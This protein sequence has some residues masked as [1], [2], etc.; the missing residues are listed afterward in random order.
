[1]IKCQKIFA[2][3]N[4]EKMILEFDN[5][6]DSKDEM[7]NLFNALSECHTKN[8]D[9]LHFSKGEYHFSDEFAFVII[10]RDK[11]FA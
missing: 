10:K 3:K 9:V 7:F 11:T 4:G 1:M 8:A 6:R 2:E 5:F